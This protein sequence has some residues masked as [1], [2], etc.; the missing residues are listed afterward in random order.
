M[1]NL[2][3]ALD[4]TLYLVGEDKEDA[5]GSFP[6]DSYESAGSY[7]LDNPGTRIYSV[8]ALILLDNI[9]LVD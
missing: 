9:E 7:Q 2:N 5:A 4:I 1:R 8:D 6:F 3:N